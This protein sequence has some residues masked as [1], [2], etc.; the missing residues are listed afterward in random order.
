MALNAPAVVESGHVVN[1]GNIGWNL[2]NPD[3]V[4]LAKDI[5]SDT[6]GDYVL[7]QYDLDEYLLIITGSITDN[8]G[9]YEVGD[10]EVYDL[11]VQTLTP[12][13]MGG[14]FVNAEKGVISGHISGV[15]TGGGVSSE[16]FTATMNY[17][18]NRTFVQ[19]YRLD[20]SALDYLYFMNNSNCIIYASMPGYAKLHDSQT[21]YSYFLS[22]LLVGCILFGL[23]RSIF[24][25][26]W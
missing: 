4:A 20:T 15:D 18:P 11:Y 13:Q 6:F 26:F 2:Y 25:R 16:D 22:C 8:T 5:V 9:R 12:E 17:Y 7:L 14:T 21:Y 23:F 19:M 1:L 10:C 3:V 24:K